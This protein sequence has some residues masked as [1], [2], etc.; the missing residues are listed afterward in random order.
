MGSEPSPL[1][2]VP[3]AAARF[4]FPPSSSPLLRRFDL[5]AASPNGAQE[6]VSEHRQGDVTVPAD[7]TANFVVI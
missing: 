5:V 1:L 2:E 3:K 4:A 6:G 7:P